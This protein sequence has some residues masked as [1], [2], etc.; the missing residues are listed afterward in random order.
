M[1]NLISLSLFWPGFDPRFDHLLT[2]VLTV[3]QHCVMW[4]QC[5]SDTYSTPCSI[6]DRCK[7]WFRSLCFDPSLTPVLTTFFD[8]CFDRWHCIMWFQRQSD[9]Y[10]TPCSI[11]DRCKIW[12]HSP[13]FDPLWPLFWPLFLPPV[14]TCS[15]P[16]LV[17]DRGKILVPVANF[18]CSA[19]LG[20]PR[21][22]NSALKPTGA[23]V[24]DVLY[25]RKAVL[26]VHQ[27]NINYF[28]L[29]K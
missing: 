27:M 28:Y 26:D 20:A 12:F 17:S 1:Q 3:E 8:T 24:D 9:I 13:C 21:N 10:S 15:T 18:R 7:I 16:C 14:L 19:W 5:Q 11:S 6:S 25:A 29:N 22:S 23:T 2:P 4:F